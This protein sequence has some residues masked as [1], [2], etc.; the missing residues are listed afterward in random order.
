[1]K[2]FICED[3]PLFLSSFHFS[4]PLKVDENSKL[5]FIH[6]IS[7]KYI[8]CEQGMKVWNRYKHMWS[9]YKD[10]IYY[11]TYKLVKWWVQWF[12]SSPWRHFS[13]RKGK[14]WQADFILKKLSK[15][16]FYS[17]RC[18]EITEAHELCLTSPSITA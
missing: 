1:M 16:K 17:Q 5:W 2:S 4:K 18:E 3:R 7:M 10:D 9:R 8:I 11:M 6:R 15:K 12:S 13:E 14:N